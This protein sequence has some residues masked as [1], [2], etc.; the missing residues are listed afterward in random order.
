MPDSKTFNSSDLIVTFG[1]LHI[2]GFSDGSYVE[3][4]Y[5]NPWWTHKSGADGEVAS[6][7]SNRLD[8]NVK[9]KLLQTSTDNDALSAFL[10]SDFAANVPQPLLIKDLNGLALYECAKA[11]IDKVPD[12][13]YGTDVQDREWNIFCPRL[14]SFVGGNS[15]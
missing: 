12:I 7:R 14:L 5:N 2:T 9:I 15:I 1:T 8:A 13:A 11:R 6:I 3:I 10:L 4:S